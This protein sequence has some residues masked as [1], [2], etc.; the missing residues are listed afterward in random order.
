MLTKITPPSDLDYTANDAQTIDITFKS[1]WAQDK[2][3]VE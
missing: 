1:D 2:S 3:P